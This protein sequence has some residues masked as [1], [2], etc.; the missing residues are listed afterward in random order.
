MVLP[1]TSEEAVKAVEVLSRAA[2]GLAFDGI[3]TSITITTYEP[4]TRTN[5]GNAARCRYHARRN[6][7]RCVNRRCRSERC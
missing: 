5:V 6:S 2:T 4:E 7:Y 1:E 3:N